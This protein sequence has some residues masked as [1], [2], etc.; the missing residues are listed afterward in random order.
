[1]TRF[2]AI[3]DA[4]L[5]AEQ[6][7]VVEAILAGPRGSLRGPF[8]PL[9]RSP[10]LADHVQRLGEHLRF[11]KT[12]PADVTELAILVTAR[13]CRAQFEWHVHAPLAAAAGIPEPVIAAIG[14]NERPEGATPALLLAHDF[15][16]AL[17]RQRAVDERL[18][19]QARESWG[20]HGVVELTAL[21]G[22]YTL[23]ALI[24]NVAEMPV[25][26][27]SRVPFEA[28]RAEPPDWC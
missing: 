1:M 26:E 14:R 5:S 21:C 7:R 11:G 4:E 18:F 8:V 23:V 25:P 19:V 28:A 3:P 9:L 15:I 13:A 16:A 27:G 22:Y 6:R 24:L 20:E 2:P 12:L 10:R 17:H